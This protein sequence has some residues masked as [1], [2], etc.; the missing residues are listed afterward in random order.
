[1]LCRLAYDPVPGLA[2][3]DPRPPAGR[4]LAGRRLAGRRLAGR[5]LAT[6]CR[7]AGDLTGQ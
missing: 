5:P 2:T 7:F 4:R 1:M 6:P 3:F